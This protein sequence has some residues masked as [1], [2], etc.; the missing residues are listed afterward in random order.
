MVNELT[1]YNKLIEEV[2]KRYGINVSI[3]QLGVALH[4]VTFDH[5]KKIFDYECI[6]INSEYKTILN[7]DNENLKSLRYQELFPENK[8]NK[9]DWA[10][11]IGHI[12]EFQSL[13]NYYC[14][15]EPLN[16]WYRFVAL[17]PEKGFTLLVAED[18][19]KIKFDEIQSNI[20][21]L[22]LSSASK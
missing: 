15:S 9:F 20:N 10:A 13:T 16:K 21:K 8:E 14:Y 5:D 19:S 3:P 1:K 4:R 7:I 11:L 18:I 2:L 17:S 12:G 22:T 6:E